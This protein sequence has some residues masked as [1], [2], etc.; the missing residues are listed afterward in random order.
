MV[1]GFL[2]RKERG[3]VNVV[4]ITGSCCM[5]GMAPLDDQAQAMVAQAVKETGVQV[6]VKLMPATA[7]A[8]GGVPRE[9]VATFMQTFQTEGRVAL[10]AV[11]VN[12]KPVA[13]GL[14]DAARLKEALLQA[15]GA[16]TKTEDV[17]HG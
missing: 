2:A 6:K 4:I 10:P 14:P 3:L 13:L 15:A 12:G 1:F 9:L 5:P 17:N 16:E 11:L 8:F 7:A